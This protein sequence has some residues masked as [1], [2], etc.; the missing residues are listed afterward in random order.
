MMLVKERD[1]QK[2]TDTQTDDDEALFWL[3]TA[4]T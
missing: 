4:T 1:D 3:E 2:R